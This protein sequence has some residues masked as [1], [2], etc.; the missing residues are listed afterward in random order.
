MPL[1]VVLIAAFFNGRRK[2]Y[3][4]S[5]LMSWVNVKFIVLHAVMLSSSIA[6]FYAI[7][8]YSFDV[9]QVAILALVVAFTDLAIVWALT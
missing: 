8:G 3:A 7:A 5:R 1:S 4:S 6:S 9:L 2:I